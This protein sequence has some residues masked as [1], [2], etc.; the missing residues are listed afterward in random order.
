[1]KFGFKNILATVTLLAIGNINSANA[2]V[3]T[4]GH[5]L[6]NTGATQLEGWLGQGDLDWTS[7]WFGNAGSSA[8]SWH[9][10]VNGA[11]PT[12]SI[13]KE[14]NPFTQAV[15][16]YGGYTEADWG[17]GSTLDPA[18][19]L[20]NLTTNRKLAF[21]GSSGNNIQIGASLFPMFGP[22]FGRSDLLGGISTL[23]RFASSFPNIF[24]SPDVMSSTAGASLNIASME[25]FTVAQAAAAPT[26]GAQGV[27]EPAPL[28][29]LGLGLLGLGIARKRRS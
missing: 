8:S 22:Q 5:L 12:F 29:L 3:I 21:N 19:F 2:G 18:A 28:A 16:F 10:A 9:S 7:I 25:T 6:N 23:G 17:A 24:G 26:T 11:G 13:F 15:Q 14:V 1:M 20:F 4:G 27:P